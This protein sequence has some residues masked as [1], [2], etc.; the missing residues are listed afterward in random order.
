MQITHGCITET[1]YL[2]KLFLIEKMAFQNTGCPK[3]VHKFKMKNLCSEI[4]S[5]GKVSF[6]C[7][8]S[9]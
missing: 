8:T 1:W 3:K 2:T 5:I 6:I 4:R 9:P 7:Q